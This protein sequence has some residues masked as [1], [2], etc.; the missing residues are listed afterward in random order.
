MSAGTGIRHSEH[1]LEDET[2][3]IFQIWIMP[4]RAGHAPSWGTRAFPKDDRAGRFVTLAS[5]YQNDGDAL[6]IHTDARVLGARLK[7]SEATEYHLGIE[8]L[9]YLVVA[10]G[11]VEIEGKTVSERDGAAIAD[12]DILKMRALTDAEVVLVDTAP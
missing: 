2:T 7:K 9:A 10:K 11:A 3:R 4:N 1:N 8:R 6:P 12:T 5:G